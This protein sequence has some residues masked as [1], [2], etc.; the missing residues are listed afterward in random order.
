MPK[1]FNND[2]LVVKYGTDQGKVISGGEYSHFADGDD[3]LV[4]FVVT[5]TVLDG[6]NVTFLSDTITIP[7]NAYLV[8][9]EFYVETAFTSGGAMTLDFRLYDTNRSTE[10]GTNGIDA[11]IAVASLTAGATIVGDGALVKTRLANDTPCLLAAKANVAAAT[12]GKGFLRV[13]W[14]M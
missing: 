13:W 6:T 10:V 14:R 12:A 5:P 3:H 1:W 11:A 2:G 8:K 7:K 4:E 9:A